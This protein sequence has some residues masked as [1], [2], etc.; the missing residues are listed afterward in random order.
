M[1]VFSCE[2]DLVSFFPCELNLFFDCVIGFGHVGFDKLFK[3]GFLYAK[4]DV[5]NVLLRSSPFFA[6]WVASSYESDFLSVFE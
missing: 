6:Y 5:N 1:L 2:F 4:V 3:N